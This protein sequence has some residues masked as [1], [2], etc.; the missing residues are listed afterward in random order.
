MIPSLVRDMADPTQFHVMIDYA[1]TTATA[2]YAIIGVASYI[3]FGNS[4]SD[5]VC[6]SSLVNGA[7]ILRYFVMQFS[8][9]LVKHSV[10]PVLTKIALWGLVVSP[11]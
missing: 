11:L 5:E 2:I 9:D 4:V 7:F 10:H 8:Q 6:S 1:F 3:M